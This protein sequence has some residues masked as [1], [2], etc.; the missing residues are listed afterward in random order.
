MTEI[1][2]SFDYM[3]EQN[4]FENEIFD[5]EKNI[6]KLDLL[7]QEHFLVQFELECF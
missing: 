7:A 4:S 1:I 2:V 5:F 3:L 6:P